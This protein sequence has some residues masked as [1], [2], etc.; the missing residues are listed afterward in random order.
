MG[1]FRFL[2]TC[3]FVLLVGPFVAC[4]ILIAW[5]CGKIDFDFDIN[6]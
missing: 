3:L 6:V 1:I 4:Y 2:G 5:M